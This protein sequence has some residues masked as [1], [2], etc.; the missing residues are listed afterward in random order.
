[1]ATYEPPESLPESNAWGAIYEATGSAGA[2][3]LFD[4][5]LQ[6]QGP[7]CL[8]VIAT[9]STQKPLPFLVSALWTLGAFSCPSSVGQGLDDHQLQVVHHCTPTWR[10]QTH[11]KPNPR[12]S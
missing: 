8:R 12:K 10:T 6:T 5:K 3:L 9:A 7:I 11:E 2:G 4:P 1:M